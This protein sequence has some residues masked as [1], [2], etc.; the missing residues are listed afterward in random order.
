MLK[1]NIGIEVS[2]KN[3]EELNVRSSVSEKDHQRAVN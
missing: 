3:G 1:E 2:E